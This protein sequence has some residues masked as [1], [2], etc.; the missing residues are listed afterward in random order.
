MEVKSF[1]DLIVWQKSIDLVDKIYLVTD[2][3][4]GDERYV[5]VSQMRRCTISVPSNI[6]EGSLRGTTKDFLRF[7]D[8]AIGSA[9]ELYTQ[10]EIAKR[11]RYIP[12]E[13]Q[14]QIDGLITEIIKMLHG[15][16]RRLSDKGFL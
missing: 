12:S 4:P 16:S 8:I 14:N 2:R 13:L 9:G 11:R 6:S 15:L 5:L 10:I 1:K 3:F 7:I